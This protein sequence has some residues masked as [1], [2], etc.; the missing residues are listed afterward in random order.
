M[1]YKI[2]KIF[3]ICQMMIQNTKIILFNN[4]NLTKIN[5]ILI[6]KYFKVR[7]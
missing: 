1:R 4:N 7:I 5:K 2:K 3:N 6:K